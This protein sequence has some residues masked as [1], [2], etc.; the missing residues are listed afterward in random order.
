MA[1]PFYLPAQWRL[2]VLSMTLISSMLSGF[3][4]SSN[5]KPQVFY[6]V[7]AIAAVIKS[8]KGINKFA[9][10]PQLDSPP[11]SAERGWAKQTH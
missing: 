8:Y 1:S 11:A 3:E 6:Q 4:L 5:E 2:D 7:H 10:L 9:F